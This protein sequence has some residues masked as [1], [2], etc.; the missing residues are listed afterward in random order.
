MKYNKKILKDI[1]KLRLL[2]NYN[3]AKTRK[4]IKEKYK[5]NITTK[6]ISNIL[7]INLSKSKI[8]YNDSDRKRIAYFYEN[9]TN[10]EFMLDYL[11]R[12]FNYDLTK[13][14]LYKFAYDNNI[15]RKFQDCTSRKILSKKDEKLIVEMYNNKISVDEIR[16]KFSFKTTKSIYDILR[17][18][19]ISL[20]NGFSHK[21]DKKTYVDF[22]LDTLDT[23]FKAY[24]LGLI[25]TD[26]YIRNDS[27][28]GK[29]YIELSLIDEICIKFL[30]NEIKCNYK[31][32]KRNNKTRNDM[33]RLII[34]GKNY[35]DNM[36]R[37]GL[38]QNK[39]Y[40]M[41]EIF[42]YDFEKKFI[43]TIIRGMIDGD[44]WIRKD[45]KEF[46]LMSAS[47]EMLEW[48]KKE[49]IKLGF[50][51]LKITIKK[52]ENMGDTTFNPTTDLYFIRSANK[53]NIE[54]LKKLIYPN[55]MGMERKY[56]RLY[57]II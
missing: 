33:F 53:H 11:N 5:I 6:F 54:L 42:L 43:P 18:N 19:N 35:I 56:N 9:S 44:G 26:G 39:T 27:I 52:K 20:A 22:K 41:G 8:K 15:K 13:Q 12:K 38:H 14:K 28:K 49:L 55:P 37:Y 45:G 24:F 51:N 57:Q 30:A 34:S 3:L 25:I 4:L 32:L 16:Y 1:Y 29:Y 2:K 23:N 50:I 17:K 7:N 36:A 40:N 46:F 47:Y 31:R 21:E 48:T 10:I